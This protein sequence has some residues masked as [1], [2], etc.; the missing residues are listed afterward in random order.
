MFPIC[1][2]YVSEY[3]QHES[4]KVELN[5]GNGLDIIGNASARYWFGVG[6][7]LDLIGNGLDASARGWI[8]IGCESNMIQ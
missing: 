2:Q 1:I 8:D 5:I 7:G 3:I 6:K 4:N